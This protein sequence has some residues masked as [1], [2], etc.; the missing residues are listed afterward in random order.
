MRIKKGDEWKTA[1]RTW[2][3]YFK[4]QVM[5]F[6]LSNTLVYFQS[7]INKILANKF[8]IFVI[9][10]LD[11]I[12]I[13]IKDKVNPL[14]MLFNWFSKNKKNDLFANFKKC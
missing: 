2:Y 8:N 9:V 14:S 1:F 3:G 4:Y 11:D 7:Y 6:K 13:Y 5:P 10:Y 12:F